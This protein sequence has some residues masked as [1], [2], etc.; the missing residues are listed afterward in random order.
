MLFS[1]A[2][3]YRLLL[4]WALVGVSATAFTETPNIV[5]ILAD[6]LGYG[7]VQSL[8]PEGKIPTPHIDSLVYS[9]MSFTNAHTTSAVCTP[10]RYSLLTGRYNWRT[11][12]ADGV[13]WGYSPH[14]IDADQMT[15]G[16][17]LQEQGYATACIG[18]WHLGMD[19]T[20]KDG[21]I[22]QT[23]AKPWSIDYEQ[24]LGHAPN[25]RGFDYFFGI[26]ASLDMF[27]FV[28]I[29]N[30]RLQGVPTVEKDIFR[31]GP[32]HVDFEGVDV[33]PTLT[34]K[35]TE[36]IDE[37][38]TASKPFFLYFP[39]TAPHTPILPTSN[40]QD[41]SGMNAYADF[42][43]QVDATVGE[44]LAA[45][46]R[47]GLSENTLVIFTSDNGCSPQA[48]FGEL[49]RFGHNPNHVFRGHKADI[50]EGGHRVPF[51]A[52]W[53]GRIEANQSNPNA[54]CLSD[55]MATVAD[56][57]EV[58]L[59]DDAG[60]DSFSFLP[61][62][63][64]DEL[65]AGRE[66]MVHHSIDG[67]FAI[68]KGRWKLALCPGSGGWSSPRP[69]RDDT[70]ARPAIQLFDLEEDI[71]ERNN[72]AEAHPEIVKELSA[73]LQSYVDEGRSTPGPKQMNDRAIDI[74][75][76]G[77]LAHAPKEKKP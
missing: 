51:V 56:L 65:P 26:S 14:L 20:L 3:L 2:P 67:S 15:V 49:K 11:R 7:D 13:T 48:S 55:L 8:N 70:S 60:V 23:D 42:V 38:A 66:A 68:T 10:T 22:A 1:T 54:V 44:V 9:G 41:K 35:M 74:Y 33:L 28:Y 12:L 36:Y 21:G 34:R 59:A 47:N 31:V 30:D 17:L 63:M 46:K 6:D 16:K 77:R 61:L 37:Q 39:L 18:K 40:W 53:P 58:P 71:G 62:L 43:M 4:V 72:L 29:E 50:Y 76:S 25:T 45:L 5:F 19:W 24:P 75:K 52:K 69:G 27:P 57:V 32:A 64:G 73:L